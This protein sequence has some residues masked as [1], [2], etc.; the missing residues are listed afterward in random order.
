ML[1]NPLK[2]TDPSGYFFLFSCVCFLGCNGIPP[3]ERYWAGVVG[4]FADKLYPSEVHVTFNEKRSKAMAD[5]LTTI[6]KKRLI[7]KAG[8]A[9]PTE[10][11]YIA[12]AIS[13]QLDL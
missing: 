9:S 7:N 2:Y 4:G 11:P 1:N 13:V 8:K 5:Q 6:S 10:M 12:K 3:F